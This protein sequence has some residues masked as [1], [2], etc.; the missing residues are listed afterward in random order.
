[1]NRLMLAFAVLAILTTIC[2]IALLAHGLQLHKH[3]GKA[4]AL[5]TANFHA[6][7][8]VLPGK[9]IPMTCTSPEPGVTVCTGQLVVGQEEM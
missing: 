2:G 8:K 3:F 7:G 9:G 4:T 6:L 1:M 5:P